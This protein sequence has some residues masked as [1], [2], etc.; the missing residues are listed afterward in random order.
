MT[1]EKLDLNGQNVAQDQVFKEFYP[2]NPPFGYVGIQVDDETGK[3]IY[4]AIEPTITEEEATI[5]Q[6]IKD[7]IIINVGVPLEILKNEDSMKNYL[8][9]MIKK[10]LKKY[11]KQIPQESEDKLKY[12]LVRDFL[13][14]GKI[15][16]LFHDPNIED[17]SCNGVN[18]PLYI[19]HRVHES[20]P[21]NI[22][23]PTDEEL[24]FI[25]TRLVYKTGNQISIANPILEG[26]LP[27]GYRAHVT[28]NEISKR[29]DTF[30]IRKFRPNPFT[31]VDLI[32][33]G[34]I[35]PKI[36]AYT[37]ILVEY[38]RSMMIC[39]AVAS[40]KTALLNSI[41]MF[42]KPEM[43][44]VSIEEVRE[45]RLHENWIPMIT[46]PSYQ[47]GVEEIDLFDLLRSALRQRPDYIIVGEVRGEE[48]YTLFQSIAVGHGGLCSIH[49]D[50]EDSVIKRLL[51]R[52]MDV[53]PM[54]LPLMN[55]LIQIRRVALNDHVVRRVESISEIVGLDQVTQQPMLET[56]F[57]WIAEHDTFEYIKPKSNEHS[58]F[59]L[60]SQINQI[61]LE[62][63]NKELDR[64][65][66]ILKWMVNI[67]V[68]SYDDVGNIIRNYYHSPEDV[69]GVAR[70]G[71]Q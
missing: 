12:Y 8:G 11:K 40:G 23:F 14:Y 41:S 52:P 30:T 65:E 26:T 2:V 7:A 68:K 47:P 58:I 67:G 71:F 64:R 45:L 54:M 20:L 59:K 57:K 56:R 42:I 51:T 24:N 27:E 43:K 34:T 9:V 36:A 5:L 21:T 37:W 44:V 6:A 35:S 53:P 32:E 55:C 19:W 38:L 46:R 61:P 70:L 1:E 16:I 48:A 69:Y 28:L 63:L 18:T 62:Q 13:G 3:K 29:G 15:D 39:G 22:V 50:S 17:I 33:L 31:V 66:T 60:I 49:A 25:V 4:N 10:I